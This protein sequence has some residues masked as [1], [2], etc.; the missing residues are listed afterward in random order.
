[1]PH[2]TRPKDQDLHQDKSKPAKPAGRDARLAAAL[3]ENLRRRK[4]QER[5]RGA[6]AGAEAPGKPGQTSDFEPDGG[7]G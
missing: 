3:R 2:M 5:G 1:M 6:P 4:A 7:Q